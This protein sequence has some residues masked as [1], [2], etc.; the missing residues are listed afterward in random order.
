MA[1]RVDAPALA[2]RFGRAVAVAGIP[3]TPERSARFVQTLD[4]TPPATRSSLYWA[5]R[6]AFI[7]GPDQLEVFDRVFDEVFGGLADP[8]TDR[9]DPNAP[10]RRDGARAGSERTS[11]PSATM[12]PRGTD[13]RD[14]AEGDGDAIRELAARAASS[15]ERLAE[16]DFAELDQDELRALRRL[17]AELALAPPPRR[18]RRLRRDSHGARL[19]LRATIRSS[20]RTGG[21]PARW[22]LRRR[23]ERPRRLV[24]L[25]DISGSMEP[26]TRAFLQLLHAAVGGAHAEAFVFATRLTRVTRALAG[27]RP[28]VAIERAAET[29]R[30]WSSGTR[31]GESLKRFND[32]HG[33]RGM[34][35]GAVVVIVSDGWERGDPRV[36]AE[37]MRRLR[38]LAYRIVWVNPRSASPEFAP[39]TGG[40]AAALPFCD[41][42]V[43]GHNVRAL[44]TVADAIAGGQSGG[45]S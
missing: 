19:D 10:S 39:S 24:F 44:S 30:D 45:G 16:R 20:G 26:Y 27:S 29:V 25:C 43:S 22:V 14:G 38:R 1:E 33:R 6:L 3:V 35:R 18:S 15:E 34:A 11:S 7:S 40:M 9:G 21:D 36:V 31:I 2:A 13:L 32:R 8:A 37:Q 4:L 41:A 12:D 17:I 5:A 28:D 23:L 42:L